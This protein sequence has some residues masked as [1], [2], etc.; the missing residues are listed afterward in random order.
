MAWRVSQSQGKLGRQK[1]TDLNRS[2]E[3]TI[4]VARN[5]W[6]YVATVEQNLDP[7]LPLVLCFPGEINQVI[8]NLL[9][10][11]AQAIKDKVTESEK[12]QSRSPLFREETSRRC[13]SPTPEAVFR[14][15]FA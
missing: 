4:T 3:S 11:A 6:K 8:L 12:R 14:T 10:N 2:I 15:T 13:Q 7:R 9:V 1:M 5:E